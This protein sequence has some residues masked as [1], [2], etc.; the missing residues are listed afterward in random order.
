MYARIAKEAYDIWS[1]SPLFSQAF[2]PSPFAIFAGKEYGKKYIAR[3]T[4]CL[5]DLGVAWEHLPN[6]AA[7]KSKFPI[8]YQDLPQKHLSGCCNMISGWADAQKAIAALRDQ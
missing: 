4:A 3:N 6:A 1:T 5:D 7:T 2:F 8:L